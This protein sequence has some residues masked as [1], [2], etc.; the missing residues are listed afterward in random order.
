MKTLVLNLP[1]PHHLRP[2]T[3]PLDAH[4]STRVI[5]HGLLDHKTN[6]AIALLTTM[7]PLRTR[8]PMFHL[9][10]SRSMLEIPPDIV[11]AH[12]RRMLL[13]RAVNSGGGR[14]P[15][16]HMAPAHQVAG[17]VS[18][19]DRARETTLLH[20]RPQQTITGS[21]RTTPNPC[22]NLPLTPNTPTLS[23]HL[24]RLTRVMGLEVHPPRLRRLG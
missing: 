8:P 11:P 23:D 17:Q 24:P 3:S 10:R 13:P 1:T 6:K 20:R 12:Q 16:V 2:I 14:H 18:R 22:E 9:L 21:I 4:Q 19:I 7:P 15:V 5:D